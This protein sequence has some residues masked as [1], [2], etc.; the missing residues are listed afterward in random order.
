MPLNGRPDLSLAIAGNTSPTM[1]LQTPGAATL[2]IDVITIE[3]DRN[4][5]T[6]ISFSHQDIGAR[7]AAGQ[8]WPHVWSGY[9]R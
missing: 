6:I 3:N 4:F 1:P 5:K 2:V 7:A 8:D 9:W